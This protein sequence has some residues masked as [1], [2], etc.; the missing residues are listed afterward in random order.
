MS[1]SGVTIGNGSIYPSPIYIDNRAG[2]GTVTLTNTTITNVEDP[3]IPAVYVLSK[4]AVTI[5]NLTST[6]N[7]VGLYVNNTEAGG[8]PGVTINDLTAQNNKGYGF[9]VYSKGPVK[10]TNVTV[11]G[12]TISGVRDWRVY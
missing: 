1:V 3:G 12:T 6:Y 8:T 10:V 2:T 7:R 5:S 11:S 9:Q 4:G